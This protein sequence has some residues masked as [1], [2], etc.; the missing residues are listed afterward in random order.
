MVG[1]NLAKDQWS[2]KV[3]GHLLSAIPAVGLVSLVRGNTDKIRS[4][5]SLMFNPWNQEAIDRIDRLLE[6]SNAARSASSTAGRTETLVELLK[7]SRSPLDLSAGIILAILGCQSGDEGKG[8]RV[9]WALSV[10]GMWFAFRWQG[11]PNAG[12]SLVGPN[13]QQ[14]SVHHIPESVV[15]GRVGF[16][17]PGMVVNP[18]R[19]RQEVA[20]F[21]AAGIVV[22]PDHLFIDLDLAIATAWHR[23]QEGLEQAGRN[24]IM[25]TG[26]AIGPT[27]Q[28]VRARARITAWD[29]VEGVTNPDHLRRALQ[30][31]QEQ[32]A[33]RDGYETVGAGLVEHLR[34]GH[35]R[36]ELPEES[37]VPPTPIEFED[38][39][40]ALIEFGRFLLGCASLCR[41]D[42]LIRHYQALGY[43]MVAVGGQGAHLCPYRSNPLS[44]S[45]GIG[46]ADGMQLRNLMKV[47]VVK[48]VETSSGQHP[49]PTLITNGEWAARLAKEGEEHGTTTGRPYHLSAF[50][51]EAVVE[52]ARRLDV[53]CLLVSKADLP[54]HMGRLPVHFGL[55][56]DDRPVDWWPSTL[57]A[58]DPDAPNMTSSRV[59]VERVMVLPAIEDEVAGVRVWDDLPQTL[60][61]RLSR[62][63]ELLCSAGEPGLRIAGIGNGKRPEDVVLKPVS[64]MPWWMRA[65]ISKLR[66]RR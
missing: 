19:F 23:R 34:Q 16:M 49:H 36:A 10:M 56:W 9:T 29:C 51:V 30:R 65:Q 37:F 60:C 53:D 24:G 35:L 52:G 31:V 47:G 6:A 41:V 64:D 20:S 8:A 43:D 50:L 59:G 54:S 63:E 1:V 22:S 39:L 3:A 55:T 62:L 27:A 28:S 15:F 61:D 11:G 26:S 57:A 40:A 48:Q 32:F 46:L 33:G 17:G 66:I 14:I 5:G 25:T 21:R 38:E 18:P 2:G 44:T 12:H 58:W 13:G 42:N 45:T 7:Y 4:W